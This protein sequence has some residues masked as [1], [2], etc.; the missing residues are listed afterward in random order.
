MIGFC[1]VEHGHHRIKPVNNEKK[2]DDMAFAPA[3]FYTKCGYFSCAGS[4]HRF[5]VPLPL[6]GRLSVS[7]NMVH[8]HEKTVDIQTLKSCFLHVYKIKLELSLRLPPSGA[9]AA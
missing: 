5:A 4:F 9:V 8:S 1:Q 7:A 6:G 2:I 3:L